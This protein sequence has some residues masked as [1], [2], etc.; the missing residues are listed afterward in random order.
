MAEFELEEVLA[1]ELADQI[2]LEVAAATKP[3][4]DRIKELEA[5]NKQ[6]AAQIAELH[7]PASAMSGATSGFERAEEF[8][9]LS[10]SRLPCSALSDFQ[11]I[12]K[13]Q[14]ILSVKN[15]FN[16]QLALRHVRSPLLRPYPHKHC[17]DCL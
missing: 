14:T 7:P 15:H 13:N 4:R 16:S 3:L 9:A 1:K 12:N 11:A 6:L 17:F 10:D 8:H 2:R 5:S